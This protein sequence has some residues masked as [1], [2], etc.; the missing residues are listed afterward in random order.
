MEEMEY[1]T[2][3]DHSPPP[4]WRAIKLIAAAFADGPS[5]ILSGIPNPAIFQPK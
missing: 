2:S 4:G 1:V 5:L 3:V